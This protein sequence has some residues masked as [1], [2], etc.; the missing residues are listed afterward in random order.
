M[1]FQK[2]GSPEARARS[3]C[4]LPDT[5]L[6]LYHITVQYSTLDTIISYS[7]KQYYNITLEIQY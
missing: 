7:I 4:S 1:I 2:Y 6:V 3:L 5:Y